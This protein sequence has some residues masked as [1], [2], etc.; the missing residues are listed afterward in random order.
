MEMTDHFNARE[1]DWK[2]WPSRLLCTS[3]RRGKT[4]QLIQRICSCNSGTRKIL[5]RTAKLTVGCHFFLVNYS[6][7]R[8]IMDTHPL[9][10]QKKKTPT[11]PLLWWMWDNGRF[12]SC[13][14]TGV[15]LSAGKA[16]KGQ[17]FK[18][19]KHKGFTVET[20]RPWIWRFIL[21]FSIYII[22]FINS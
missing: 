11:P 2:P 16:G 19:L 5:K 7:T 18:I 8:I 20:V 22:V 14:N 9:L 3:T 6:Q 4:D 17:F 1:K 12:A 10:P 13:L 15:C 21:H